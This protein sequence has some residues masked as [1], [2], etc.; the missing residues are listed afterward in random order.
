[1]RD[2]EGSTAFFYACE[3]DAFDIVKIMINDE[4][5]DL[6]IP[7]EDGTTPLMQAIIYKRTDSALLLIQNANTCKID[8]NAERTADY[9]GKT[10]L[11]IAIIKAQDDVINALQ[12][13]SADDI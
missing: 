3:K 9:G 4:R 11:D 10:A 13:A 2:T 8:L 5:V 12:K 1:M 6:N 7:D